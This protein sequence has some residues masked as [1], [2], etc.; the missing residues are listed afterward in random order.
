[1]KGVISILPF[2]AVLT[3]PTLIETNLILNT[4]FK[5]SIKMGVENNQKF[6]FV[7]GVIVFFIV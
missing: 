5:A 6:L 1:M 7:L 4:L 3:N 2:R